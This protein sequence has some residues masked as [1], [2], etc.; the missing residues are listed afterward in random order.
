MMLLILVTSIAQSKE[1]FHGPGTYMAQRYFDGNQ[2]NDSNIGDLEKVWEFSSGQIDE[3]L[4]VQS[5]P[6]YT[7]TKIISTSPKSIFALD[8][9]SGSLIW[10][11]ELDYKINPRSITFASE[12]KRRVYVPSPKGILEIDD[13]G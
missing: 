9:K 4:T 8:P 12:P 1:W 2:I 13:R 11:V 6:V 7:G 10:Q 3:R 5:S